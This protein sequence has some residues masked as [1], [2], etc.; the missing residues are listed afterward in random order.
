M[1]FLVVVLLVVIHEFMALADS[2]FSWHV[3]PELIQ[4]LAHTVLVRIISMG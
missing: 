1:I 4:R 2:F 3:M